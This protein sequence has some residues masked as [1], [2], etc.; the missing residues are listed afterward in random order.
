MS[1]SGYSVCKIMGM[2]IC[3]GNMIAGV[4]WSLLDIA[5]VHVSENGC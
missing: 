3:E 5:T 2:R 1:T 4:V